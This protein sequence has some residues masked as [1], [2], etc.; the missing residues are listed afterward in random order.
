MTKLKTFIIFC[1][2]CTNVFLQMRLNL[3]FLYT[4]LVFVFSLTYA[5]KATAQATSNSPVCEGNTINLSLS[6]NGASYSWTGPNGFTSISKNP[7]ISGASEINEGDYTVTVTPSSGSPTTYSTYVEVIDKPSPP[8]VNSTQFAC[9]GGKFVL[10]PSNYDG[11]YDY[12]WTKGTFTSSLDSLYFATATS[13]IQGTYTVVAS[14]QGCASS[15]TTFSL[16]VMSAPPTP[17]IATATSVCEGSQLIL[18]TS[19]GQG[20]N[21][22]WVGPGNFSSGNAVAVISNVN[23]TNA[24]Q[25]EVS[26][27]DPSSG[28]VSAVSK[29]IISVLNLPA[30]PTISPNNGGSLS[31]CEGGNLVLTGNSNLSNPT[32]NWTGPAGNG[33]TKIYTI[34]GVTTGLSGTYNLTVFDGKCN[35]RPASINVIINSVPSQPTI[36]ANDT[37]LCEGDTLILNTTL[38]GQ[39]SYIWQGPT[40]FYNT[41]DTAQRIGLVESD[42]GNYYLRTLANGCYSDTAFIHISIKHTPVLPGII[43]YGPVCANSPILLAAN[44]YISGVTYE[45]ETPS[46]AFVFDSISKAAVAY[47]DSGYYSLRVSSGGCTSLPVKVYQ[48]VK[49]LIK[50]TFKVDIPDSICFGYSIN[51]EVTTH[52]EAS[53]V[54]KK[55]NTVV[56]FSRFLP[57]VNAQF[58]DS[59]TYVCTVTNSCDVASNIPKYV[60]IL[61][62]PVA[63][64]IG[65]SVICDFEEIELSVIDG[66]EKYLWSTGDTLNSIEVDTYGH[67]DVVIVNLEACTTKVNHEIT[68]TCQ[69]EIY[70]PTAFTPNNDGANDQ[71]V[72]YTHNVEEFHLEIFNR[73]G[74]KVFQTDNPHDSW[75]GYYNNHKL[76]AG[77]YAYNYKYKTIHRYRIFEGLKS[78]SFLLAP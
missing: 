73:L 76:P 19:N 35:S 77:I 78:G 37:I 63:K 58:Q 75:D 62:S 29:K 70:I 8:A 16:V 36:Q 51:F 32:Y 1:L 42:S 14:N 31:L 27:T 5:F 54:W 40:N 26:F 66:Y 30:T 46:G 52:E 28:C 59:G 68:L 20:L 72:F 69:P 2:F 45:W 47:S 18:S 34:N 64:I 4:L 74:V 71:F 61:P 25:Y 22:A 60:K 15:P 57:I 41:Q 49:H 43:S 9:S 67:F 65:D 53:Y 6:I 24:G 12:I 21:H 50:P 33:N 13:S 55:G 39:L 3:R 10:Y 7:T 17:V 48:R 11:V 23:S 44:S 56:G 38:Q